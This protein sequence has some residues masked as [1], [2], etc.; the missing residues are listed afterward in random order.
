MTQNIM[1]YYERSYSAMWICP[2]YALLSVI[3]FAERWP[4]LDRSERRAARRVLRRRARIARRFVADCPENFAP[5]SAMIEAELAAL[6]GRYERAVNAYERARTLA[7]EQDMHW[8]AG[9]ASERLAKLAARRGHALIADA[10]LASAEA[11]YA[12]W[13]AVE[14]VRLVAG[15]RAKVST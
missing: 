7:I 11:S 9:L 12:A 6:G 1:G 2:T 14:L 8:H 10:A 15:D 4:N 5:S 13:G 3:V